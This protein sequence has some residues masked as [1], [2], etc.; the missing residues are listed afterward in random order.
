MY[1]AFIVPQKRNIAVKY[2][3]VIQRT[4]MEMPTRRKNDRKRVSLPTNEKEV[5]VNY[6]CGA[7]SPSVRLPWGDRRRRK[8]RSWNGRRNRRKS[9]RRRRRREGGR[10]G[11][12]SQGVIVLW[13]SPLF[14]RSSQ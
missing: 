9:E 7:V 14:A 10:G 1:Q 8:R 3:A 11:R 6:W 13:Y 2:D 12:R 5:L 4:F